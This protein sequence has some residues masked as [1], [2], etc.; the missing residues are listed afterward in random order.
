[1]K[2][3]CCIVLRLET[4]QT[5]NPSRIIWLL[6]AVCFFRPDRFSMLDD[7]LAVANSVC[8]LALLSLSD[9]RVRAPLLCAWLTALRCAVLW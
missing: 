9:R 8:L 3:E 2:S 7:M 1:M 5:A 4:V 6:V